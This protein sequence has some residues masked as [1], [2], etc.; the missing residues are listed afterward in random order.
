MAEEEVTTETKKKRSLVKLLVPVVLFMSGLGGAGYFLVIGPKNAAAAEAAASTTTEVELGK[1]V[2]LAPLTIAMS[3]GR[4]LKVG[5]ALQ[6][7][8]EPKEHELNALV[9][10][11]ATAKAKPAEGAT[12]TLGGQESKALDAAIASLG[13]STYIELSTPGGRVEARDTLTELI[14]EAYH[15]DVE[16]VFFT[17]F[18]MS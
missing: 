14:K 4:V 17:E 3:D 2:R 9:G 5:L 7:V 15:G 1:I 11:K 18:V 13:S 8:A 16:D 6:M 12:M 10:L